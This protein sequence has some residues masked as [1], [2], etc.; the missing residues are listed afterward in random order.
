MGVG[1][2]PSGG[3]AE[4][5]IIAAGLLPDCG[6]KID[7]AGQLPHYA[8]I[9]DASGVYSPDGWGTA[10]ARL[11]YAKE[12]DRVFGERNYGGDMVESTL[13]NVDVNVPYEDVV[14]SR[15][16]AVRAEPIL[17]LYEQ[18]RVHHVGALV[19][20]S[21]PYT[22]LEDEL[23]RFTALEWVGTGSPNRADAL[24]WVL[25]KLAGRKA[26]EFRAW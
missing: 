6:C 22:V 8:V 9:G 19:K 24:V 26:R 11:F 15:G 25:T 20:G 2:D 3:A 4:Q 14:A 5:G 12:A 7:G 18:F 16:K 21:S 23:T 13:R 17:A 1:V 10:T